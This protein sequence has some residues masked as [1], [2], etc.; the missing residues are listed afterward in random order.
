MRVLVQNGA[1]HGLP[2]R[3]VESMVALFP[4]SWSR[5][6]KSIVLCAD[7][8]TEVHASF[9]PKEQSLSIYWPTPPAAPTKTE[10]L[11]ALLLSLAVVSETGALPKHLTAS[12]RA[13]YLEVISVVRA[14]CLP[15]LH[16]SVA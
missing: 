9:H 8:A 13:A 4:A 15:L 12:S 7:A 3:T 11:D 2:R 16:G 5:A 6:V 14:Q 1:Q 10:A